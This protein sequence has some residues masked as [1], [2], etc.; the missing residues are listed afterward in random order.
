M[1]RLLSFALALLLAAA[2]AA[3][4]HSGE[5]YDLASLKSVDAV[6]KELRFTNPYAWLAVTYRDAKGQTVAID[7]ELSSPGALRRQGWQPTFPAAGSKV[8]VEFHPHSE[9]GKPIGLL[10]TLTLP[11]GKKLK[12][13]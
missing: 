2:P 13:E 1:P 11:D 9:A 12:S 4:H 6:V 7:L 10:T 5:A 8:K 3:A